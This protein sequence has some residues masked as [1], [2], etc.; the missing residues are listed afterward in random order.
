MTTTPLRP[1]LAH[2]TTLGRWLHVQAEAISRPWISSVLARR[3]Y[4]PEQV[5]SR[6]T[7]SSLRALYDSL[8][9]A[10]ESGRYAALDDS[11]SAVTRDGYLSGYPLNDLLLILS[12]LKSEVWQ[13]VAT[14]YPPHE[15]LSFLR[16]IDAVFQTALSYQARVFAD[17]VQHDLASELNRTRSQLIK[18][19]QTKSRFISI[20]AHELKTPLTL[21]QGYSDILHRELGL[22]GNEQVHMAIAGLASGAQRLLTTVNDMIA[23]SQIDAQSLQLNFQMVSLPH[24]LQ[25][26]MQD[27][28]ASL[29]ERVLNFRMKPIP[30]ELGSFYADP[31]R[32]YQVF[33]YVVGNA[34]KYTPDGGAITITINLLDAPADVERFVEVGVADT[35][36]GIAPEDLPHL[37]DKFYSKTDISRHSSGR[38][39]FKGGGSGLGLSV[40]KGIVE[41]HGG[42]IVVESAGYDEDACPG[43]TV[44]VFLPVRYDPPSSVGRDRLGLTT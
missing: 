14:A 40:V 10:L 42:K 31:Q 15:A 25:I 3:I 26:V 36:I 29:E 12:S 19:D 32:V 44:R 41:A 37:F 11:I 13:A 1:D 9:D 20:A 5:N 38:T 39:K 17:L 33:E 18:L 22:H 28:R 6:L 21:I 2:R 23:V 35:G 43:T 4:R 16:S 8:A 30:P 24:I 27:L 7:E 34:I